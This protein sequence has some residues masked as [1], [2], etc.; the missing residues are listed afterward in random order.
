MSSLIPLEIVMR[1]WLH[2]ATGNDSGWTAWCLDHPGFATWAPT[3]CEVLSRVPAKISEYHAWLDRHGLHI[4]KS[5]KG[6]QVVERVCGNEVMFLPDD[7]ACEDGEIERT[8]ELIA[9]SRDDLI[10]TVS[11]LP[12]EALDWDPPYRSFAQW[13]SWE[14]VRSILAHI[15]NTETQYYLPH[16][17]YS[18]TL[19][20]AAPDGDWET[21]GGRGSVGELL[22]AE[23]SGAGNRPEQSGR[24][25]LT[26]GPLCAGT[27][28]S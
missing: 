6:I 24:A 10:G 25:L 23:S 26:T 7:H 27:T 5:E 4:E 20:P 9:A 22:T 16:V 15:A 3:E 18:P 8:I 1:I 12:K 21:E 13:A 14:S 28:T 11:S 2:E 19:A 17:G